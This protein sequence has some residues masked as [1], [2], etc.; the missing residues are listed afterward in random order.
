MEYFHVYIRPGL[1]NLF[2]YLAYLQD[3]SKVKIAIATMGKAL[4]LDRIKKG[5]NAHCKKNNIPIFDV[6][7]YK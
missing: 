5:L 3:G 6:K 4:Y 1:R 2:N 7:F